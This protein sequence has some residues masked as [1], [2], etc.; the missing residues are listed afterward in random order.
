MAQELN[1]Q[2]IVRRQKMNDLRER[3]VDP[4]GQRFER[5]DYSIDLKEKYKD[6][7]K[8]QL[9]E[10]HIPASVA[11]RIMSNIDLD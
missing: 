7:D 5:T 6:A 3:G 1:D 11:G 9:H 4:F 2:E 8:E 10:M